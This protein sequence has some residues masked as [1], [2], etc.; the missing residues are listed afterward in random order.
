MAAEPSPAPPL[1]GPRGG[2]C[3]VVEDQVYNLKIATSR[4]KGSI[5]AAD[6]ILTA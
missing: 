2:A 4:Q 1:G 6:S 5:R 3:N